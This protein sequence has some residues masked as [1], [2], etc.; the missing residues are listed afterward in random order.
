MTDLDT[1]TVEQFAV[2]I[3]PAADDVEDRTHRYI[4]SWREWDAA[5]PTLYP[6]LFK[7]LVGRFPW[8]QA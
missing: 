8:E 1:L 7:A 3:R 5:G 2:R 6:F 4:S